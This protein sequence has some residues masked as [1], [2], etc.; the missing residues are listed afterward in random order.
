[1]TVHL[2]NPSHVSFGIGVITP[3]WLYVLAGATPAAWGTPLITDETLEPLALDSVSRRR[4]RHRHPHRQRAARLRDRDGWR[5]QR[6]ATVVF[7]GIHATLYPGGGARARRGARRRQRRRRRGVAAGRSPTAARAPAAAVR[8]RPGRRRRF[9]PARWDLLPDGRYMWALGAD[10]SR[11]PEA[12]LVLLGVADRRPAAAAAR[13]STRSS[14]EIVELRRRG[15]P[16]HRARRRQLLSGDA[17]GS[18][19]W[20]RGS[21]NQPRLEQL[22]GDPRRAVRADGAAGAAAA[23]TWCS[24]RRSRWKPPRIRSS[25]TRCARRTSRARSSASRRYA[26]RAEGRLQGLQRGRRGAG[27][28]AA[29]RSASTASTSSARSSSGCRAIAPHTFDA[30]AEWPSGGRHV[31]AVRHADAVPGDGRLRGVG[32]DAS[33]TTPH[34]SPACRSRGTG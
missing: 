22:R 9:V 2:V 25:S 24:S 28:A 33:A 23:T 17:R 16:V 21:S 14:S 6:G 20:P 10:R 27:R 34:A 1:M 5:A 30:T 13:A 11:L 3:R 12:L 32:E 31:R 7:G 26:G 8:R 18:A 29:R 19:R 4:R 15:L